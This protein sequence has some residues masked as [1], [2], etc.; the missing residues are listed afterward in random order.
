MKDVTINVLLMSC[1]LV[2]ALF[3]DMG[4]AVIAGAAAGLYRSR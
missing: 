1:L 4:K 2:W 3:S